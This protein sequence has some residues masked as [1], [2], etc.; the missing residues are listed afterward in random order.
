MS[1]HTPGPWVTI[2]RPAYNEVCIQHANNEKG[3]P[4]L[5]IAKITVRECWRDEQNA[6]ARLV[7]AA[8]DLL[9]ALRDMLSGWKYIRESHGDLYGVGWDRAQEKAVSAIAKA[10]GEK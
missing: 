9:E 7:S 10:V 1:N 8:P 6:N 2:D 5:N 4:S 3:A